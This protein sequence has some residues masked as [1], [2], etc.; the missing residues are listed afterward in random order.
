MASEPLRVA[1]LWHQ[2]QPYYKN[3]N[4]YLLPW[5]R[6]HA[7]KD[8]YD[9]AAALEEFPTIRQTINVVPSLLVQ[10][11]DYVEHGATDL[12]LDLTR[13]PAAAL[14][15]EEKI[16]IL[17]Y[18]FLCNTE[19]MIL[20]YPRYAE[21]FTRG[22]RNRDDMEALREAAAGFSAQDWLDLQVWYTLTWIGE[23]SRK[24]EPFA[25]LLKK[26][27]NFTEEEKNALIDASLGIVAKVIP[28][29]RARMESGQVELSVTPFYHPI[30]PILCDSYTAL[31]AM[32]N[33]TL[34]E[35]HV[36]FPE[37]AEAHIV[38]A[39]ALFRERFGALPHG[40]W[41]SE[42]S[43][44]DQALALLRGAGL[45]WAA[46]DE[47]VLRK[48]LGEGWTPLAK[49]FPY[50]LKTRSGPLWMVFRDHELSDAIGFVYS[51]WNP[52][53]AALDFYNRL[54]EIRTKII[55]EHGDEA[56]AQAIVPVIL[57]GENCWE[58][59]L[60]NG[61]PFLEALYKLLSA[62]GEIVT[63]TINDAI[64]DAPRRPERTLGRIYSGSWIG[65]N[66]KIWIG[67]EEDN[68]AW[69]ALV[70]AREALMRA[71]PTLDAARFAE[72]MEEIYIA[73]GSDWF[74]WFGDEN[75]VANQDDFDDLFRA[76]LRNV[77]L[78]IG[79][80]PPAALDRPIRRASRKASVTP[81]TGPISPVIDG[82]RSTAREWSNAGHFVVEKVGGAMHHADA[83]ERRIW[84]GSDDRN[85]Y[86]RFDTPLPLAEG[87]LIRL[88][89]NGTR[90]V[91]I[92]FNA[93]GVG[94]EALADE[95]GRVRIAGLVAA[96]AETLEVSVPLD[97]LDGM[98]T[99]PESV[100]IICE[101][102]ENGHQTE[103]FPHQGEVACPLANGK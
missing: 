81:P 31:E 84:F 13:R 9:I 22:S 20:P 89:L 91:V 74:W 69:D 11:I 96:V 39:I 17:R 63:T 15:D 66:F 60:E 36:M 1:I 18:F 53:A 19:R 99:T 25:A 62:S 30:L 35:H 2:H 10:L 80:E 73:E 14:V 94:I 64:K 75:S 55:Q 43:V 26:R 23:Y 100:G 87:Q 16:T 28:L 47:G 59:Y 52:E 71:K 61:R 4:R 46:T 29:Y 56:L 103:R 82:L 45:G 67:H 68:T 93:G 95:Q 49:Y 34:P 33:A 92:Q 40:V 27:R 3:G 102:F 42:G 6:L 32:P 90:S 41:P 76:H 8:Y 57:D 88:T 78:M 44:S 5:A 98:G 12:V 70:E 85:F 51:N 24:D 101:I 58:Y 21:L 86:L 79:E 50:L 7:T 54:V 48:T 65:S 37:D 72:A 97:H 38:R 77:Y 83:F